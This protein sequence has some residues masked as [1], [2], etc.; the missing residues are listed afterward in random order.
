[1]R[2]GYNRET[3]QMVRT[4]MEQLSGG[5]TTGLKKRACTKCKYDM[6]GL[7]SAR[8]PECGT[9]NVKPDRKELSRREAKRQRLWM[10]VAPLIMIVVGC[11]LMGG[12]NFSRNGIEGL[13][14]YAI[15]F[16]ISLAIGLFVY[17]AASIMWIGFDE[18]LPVTALRL[19]GVYALADIGFS[20][21]GMIPRFGMV[22]FAIWLV[23]AMIYVGLLV[24]VMDIETEDAVIVAAITTVAKI[25]V[26]FIV[27]ATLLG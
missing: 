2:C 24:K 21:V 26:V 18:P 11:G 9:V 3:Q 27:V 8:C 7:Q 4:S 17:F 6:T 20:L 12:L 15:T 1:M 5:P 22:G 25:L 16:G 13:I 23:P 14:A 19:T 10:W